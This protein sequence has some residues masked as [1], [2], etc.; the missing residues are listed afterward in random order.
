MLT[1]LVRRFAIGVI[2]A[3]FCLITTMAFAA[4]SLHQDIKVTVLPFEVNAGDDLSYLKDSLPELLTDRLQEAGFD[5]VNQE[6]VIRLVEEKG[7]TRF[8]PTSAREIALLVGGEF[9]VYGSLNQIGDSLTLDA[10]L[11]DAYAKGPGKKISVTKKGLI[12]LLPAVDALVDRM[13]MDLLRQDVVA[14]VGVEGTQVLDKEVVMMRLTLQKGDILTAKSVNTALKNIYDL[15]YFDDVQVKVDSVEDGKKV[16]FVVKEKPRIQALGVRGADEIDSEDIL[17]AVSTKKGG[18]VNP[19]VLADDIRVIREMYRKE[20]Y[21]KA[22]ITHEVEDAGTGIARLTFVVDEG[23][24]LYIENIIIDGAKLMDPDDVKDV[25]ALQERGMFSWI[26]DSGVLKEELLERDAAAIMALYQSKGFLTAKVG[27]PDVEIKDSGIDVIYRV[28]EGDRFKMGQTLFKGDL[29]EDPAQLIKVTSIDALHDEDEYFD[30]TL[31]KND[32][33]A[34]T[35]YYNNYGYAYA[36]VGVNLQDNQ[37]TKVVDV[38]YHIVKHQR[39]HI[40]RVL[41]EGNTRTRDN[42]IM[43]EMRLADGDRFS[44][45]KLKRSSQRLTNLDFFEKVDISPVPTGNPEE[46]DLVVKVKDK[47]TGKISGGIGYSTYDGVFFGGT[48]GEKNLF[49]KGYQASFEGQIGGT[50]TS[51]VAKFIN[52]RINDTDLGFGIQAHNNEVEYSQYSK[53]AIGSN[54]YFFYPLGEY[55]TLKWDYGLE[56][57]N[58]TDVAS[59]ASDDVKDDE[60]SHLASMLSA[61]ISRNT[62]D[63]YM[64]PTTGTKLVFNLIFAGGPIGGTDD[65]IKYTGSHDWY[66]PV[67]EKVVFHTKVWAGYIHEN[68][69]G[70]KIP[71][72]PRFELGGVNSIRGY[73]NYDITPTEGPDSSSTLGGDKAFYTNIELKRPISEE[74]GITALAFFDAGNSWKEGEMFFESVT[75]YGRKQSFGLYKSVGAGINWNSPMGPVGLVYGYALDQ[76]D[77]HGRHKVELLMGQQF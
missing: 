73:S 32:I 45:D 27:Q 62:F 70:G 31:L 9:S 37:E 35:G 67:F 16:I 17:E 34:L 68:F 28:W 21:Y 44:G 63:N 43:R 60:G 33:E 76:L 29:I 11:V 54:L 47:S 65:Y 26:S 14:E 13:R 5:V 20:G 41:I 57:Y 12:N 52:P 42:I 23:P 59:D 10:R 71:T 72:A 51:Y 24:Q 19:K 4:E 46:M 30:R 56:S 66:T 8:D 64:S 1:S 74:L 58:I 7:Y 77:D 48:I 18:V 6:E 39:V 25:L 22:K 40:R 15:G 38:V 49:G 61:S 69:G 55:T 53:D 3:C 2:T 36:D 50:R 75:R